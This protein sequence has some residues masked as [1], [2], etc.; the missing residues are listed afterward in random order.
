MARASLRD[1]GERRFGAS[2][3]ST[4]ALIEACNDLEALRRATG[5]ILDVNSWDELIAPLKAVDDDTATP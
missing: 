3:A 1:L 5:S 4:R 2:D